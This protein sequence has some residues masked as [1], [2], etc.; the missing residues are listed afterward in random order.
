MVRV[1]LDTGLLLKA[2]VST[3]EL[4]V[5]FYFFVTVETERLVDAFAG[6]VTLEAVRAFEI[7]MA[8]DQGTWRK[9]PIHETFGVVGGEGAFGERQDTGENDKQEVP[10]AHRLPRGGLPSR[11]GTTPRDPKR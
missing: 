4:D 3:L 6:I 5:L 7:F 9:H 2:V 10:H 8:L 1:A 11:T